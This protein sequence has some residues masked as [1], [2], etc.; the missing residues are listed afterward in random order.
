MGWKLG[1]I[2]PRAS[3]VFL[4]LVF[5]FFQI[6]LKGGLALLLPE[7]VVM[8]PLVKTIAVAAARTI[9]RSKSLFVTGSSLVFLAA[10]PKTKNDLGQDK[11]PQGLP[12]PDGGQGEQLGHQPVPQP[13]DQKPDQNAHAYGEGDY[14]KDLE[15]FHGETVVFS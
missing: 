4:L 8:L 13:H 6:G 11:D 9:G 5:D 2:T 12:K 10:A 15:D 3:V 14:P 1:S 7:L